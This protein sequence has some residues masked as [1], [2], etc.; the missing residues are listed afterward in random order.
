[1]KNE[2]EFLDLSEMVLKAAKDHIGHQDENIRAVAKALLDITDVATELRLQMAKPGIVDLSP[3]FDFW[4]ADAITAAIANMTSDD[5]TIRYLSRALIDQ[6]SAIIRSKTAFLEA[7]KN[8]GLGR[9]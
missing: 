2:F 1:M 4:F 9:N 7:I 8:R 5:K 3:Y 6:E